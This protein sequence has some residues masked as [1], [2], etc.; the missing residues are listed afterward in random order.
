MADTVSAIVPAAGQGRRFGAGINKVYA[1]LTDK[2]VLAHTL[3]ALSRV[4]AIAEIVVVAGQRELAQCRSLVARFG[5]DKV[6]A[7]VPGGESR[8]RSVANGLRGISAEADLV[9]IHD[10]ARP[11]CSPWL[12]ERVIEAARLYGAATAAVPLIDTVAAAVGDQLAGTLHREGLRAIQTPQ[13]FRRDLIEAAH[14][15]ACADGRESTDDASLVE[16]LGRAVVLVRG[17]RRN[18]KITTPDDLAAARA[19]LKG[20]GGMTLHSGIGYDVHQFAPGR[21]LVLAGVNIPAEA[22]LL[23]HSDADV[24][25]HA[26]MDALLGAAG[27][28][29][30][31]RL[32]PDDDPRYADA[33]SLELLRAVAS[34]LIASGWAPEHIDATLIMEQPKIAPHVPDMRRRLAEAIGLPEECVS[35]KATTNEGLGAFGRGEGAAALAVATIRRVG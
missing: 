12:I 14:A 16:R 27:R 9:V 3:S 28:G 1:R 33:N 35:I 2:P 10:G 31:G 25:S 21:P 6:R 32:Y 29:D 17:E 11:L 26:V 18:I 19:W 15:R 7:V 8:Q 20:D 13:A 34:D 22:G 30:I 4:P 23:G 5:F 24:I